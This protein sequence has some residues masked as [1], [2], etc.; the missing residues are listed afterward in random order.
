[1]GGEHHRT[2]FSKR[3]MIDSNV[4]ES[5]L[6]MQ[7]LYPDIFPRTFEVAPDRSWILA[8]RVDP[9]NRDTF[10]KMIGLEGEKITP[11]YLGNIRLQA[12]IGFAIM[13]FKGKK[14]P[15]HEHVTKA[16]GIIKEEEETKTMPMS[17][18]LPNP[19]ARRTVA[20]I[21]DI[22]IRRLTKM[23][24]DPHMRKIYSAMAELGI[25]PR[26][27]SPKNLGVSRISNKLMILD[28][29]LWEEHRQLR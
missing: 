16:V 17:R 23:L 27:F 22:V 25:P 14:D 12:L 21:P 19:D 18:K 5:D 13:Y 2:G 24:S 8:E 15:E 7:M 28:A 26:E 10:I 20:K 29:S 1:M 11:G 9:I 4:W 3:H 6:K